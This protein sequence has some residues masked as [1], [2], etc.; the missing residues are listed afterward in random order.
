MMSYL[1]GFCLLAQDTAGQV[2][3]M[4]ACARAAGRLSQPRTRRL[5]RAGHRPGNQKI[6]KDG[7][8]WRRIGRFR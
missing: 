6:G 3:R 5:A 4:P 1:A 8:A 2:R 7:G